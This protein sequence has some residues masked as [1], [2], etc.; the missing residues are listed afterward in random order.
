MA[1]FEFA[2]SLA[3]GNLPPVVRKLKVAAS[4]D[5]KYGDAVNM[6]SSQLVKAGNG[7]GRPVGIMAQ[8]AAELAANTLVE[9]HIIMPWHVWRATASADATSNVLN[10]ERGYDLSDTTQTV[11]LADTSGGSVQIIDIDADTNTSVYI[12]FM[13]PFFA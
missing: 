13:T 7:T 5:L 4:Q 9:V 11:N 3:G 8:D 6:S 1:N 2:Y 12:Q 10:G